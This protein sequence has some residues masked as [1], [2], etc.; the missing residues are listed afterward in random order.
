M[1]QIRHRPENAKPF[2]HRYSHEIF[3]LDENSVKP[4]H[5]QQSSSHAEES[6]FRIINGSVTVPAGKKAVWETWTTEDGIRSFFAPDCKIDPKP[7]GSFEIYFLPNAEPGLRGADDMVFLALQPYDMISFTWNAP[8]SLPNVRGHRTSV[9]VWFREAGDSRTIVTLYHSG[10]GT[11]LEWDDAYQYFKK[12][13][14]D[15]VLP[16]LKWRFINGPVNWQ[17]PPVLD[18]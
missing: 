9:V 14:N 8:P 11:G 13:W 1:E 2:T 18:E 12:A 3:V 6:C 17:N 15:I 16:R 5:N 7:G 4:T 10:W